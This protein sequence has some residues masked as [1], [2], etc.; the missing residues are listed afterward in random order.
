MTVLKQFMVG[1]ASPSSQ[2]VRAELFDRFLACAE[3]HPEVSVGS[4]PTNRLP[5]VL[6]IKTTEEVAHALAQQFRG[7][8]IIEPDAPLQY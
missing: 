8:L 7:E 6:T 3:A 2:E 1:A 4:R 5:S